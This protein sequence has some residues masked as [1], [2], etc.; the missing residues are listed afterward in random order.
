MSKTQWVVGK[1][2]WLYKAF[3]WIRKGLLQRI[4]ACLC[5]AS[6]GGYGYNLYHASVI[7]MRCP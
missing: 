4:S 2:F 5:P 6:Y 7:I 3:S 1:C